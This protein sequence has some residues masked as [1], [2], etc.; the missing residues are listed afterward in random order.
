MKKV[1]LILASI[2]ILLIGIAVVLMQQAQKTVSVQEVAPTDSSFVATSTERNN[3]PFPT[4]EDG[5]SANPE[6]AS[7]SL[8]NFLQNTDVT[9]DN[10]DP[11]NFFLGNRFP[12]NQ[13]D[14]SPNY[15]ILYSENSQFFNITL[16]S[17][18]LSYARSEAETYLKSV[19]KIPDS[20]M[21]K[22]QYSLAVP[23]AVNQ[24]YSGID[25]KFSFCPGSTALN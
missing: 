20:E 13:S 23:D 19:L 6:T 15:V 18:P 12:Q 5:S 10:N 17:E 8:P 22:L 2:T 25:L 14:P 4:G 16:L 3:N 7:Q 9:S 21:C 1:L 24:K 11:G